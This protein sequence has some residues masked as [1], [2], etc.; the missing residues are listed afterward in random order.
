MKLIVIA[1]RNL[2]RN[3]KR[4]LITVSSIF[5]GV[6]LC[7]LMGSMQQGSYNNMIENVV[8]FYSGYIQ[9]HNE[10]YWE[11]KNINN[12]FLESDSLEKAITAMDQ[13]EYIL[14]RLE[15]FALVSSG[16]LTKGAMVMGVD[17]EKENNLTS[18]G[19]KIIA[20][21]YLQEKDDG[22]LLGFKL[23]EKLKIE[24]GDTVVL[25]GQGYHGVTAAGKYPVRGL[26]KSSN[27]NLNRRLVYFEI[28]N[29]QR[30]YGGNKILT[31]YV[32]MV[33]DNKVAKELLPSLKDKVSSPYKVKSWEEM[34]PV[35]LQQIES[36]KSSAMVMKAIL[37]IVI[38]FGIFGTVMMM[39]SERKREFG[40]MMAVGMQKSKLAFTVFIETLFMGLMG[41]VMGFLGS[42]PVVGY[43]FYHPIPLTGKVAEWMSDLGFEPFMFFAWDAQVFVNQMLVVFFITILISVFPFVRIVRM[44]GIN[45]L[46][47]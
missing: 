26:F 21:N 14:P 43:F 17:P 5:L 9:I 8:N 32:V 1:W 39:I 6:I 16:E 20:G 11:D 19:D 44:S 2:W 41:V 15:S 47:G 25:L 27:P 33:K 12:S 4:T 29:A 31:S 42:M 28:S 7:S 37:Y 18:I 24:V 46:K 22:V 23:A 45:A 34:F 13:V 10:D 38:M 40:V 3:K 36:D 35:L 30:F